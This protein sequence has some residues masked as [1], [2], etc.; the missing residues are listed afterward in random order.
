MSSKKNLYY[1]TYFLI[2]IGLLVSGYLLFNHFAIVAGKPFETD[3]C[4]IVFGKG[5]NAAS[6]SN[7]SIF[8]NIPVGGW[9]LIYL[10]VLLCLTILSQIFLSKLNEIIQ[11]AFWI[12]F[13]ALF[14]SLF[15][16]GITALN[17]VLLC[18]FCMVF[19]ILNFALFLLIKKLS[20]KSFKELFRGLLKAL[21]IV[22]LGKPV[23]DHFSKWKWLTLIIPLILALAIYQWVIMEGQNIRIQKLE[24]YDPLVELEKFEAIEVWDIQVSS[25]DPMLGPKDAPVSLVVFSD[26]QCDICEMFATNFEH[27]INYNKGKLNIIFKYFPLSSQ[28]NPI[29]TDDLH[30]S[31]CK[32]ALAAEAAHQQG[33][34][35][36]YHDAMFEKGIQGDEKL[37]VA[38][39]QSLNL[40]MEKFKSDYSSLKSQEKITVDILEGNRLNIDGTP[41]VFLNGRKVRELSQKNINFLVKYLSH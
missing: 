9:G 5:C 15:Y 31:A 8:M 32:A 37:F 1:A 16:I 17:P 21:G 4:S 6:F 10:S 40:N 24:S 34:F 25:E 3:L 12:S 2:T 38:I 28:C 36:E 23:S 41:T 29:I 27:L 39:A 18:P 35:W 30:P 22:F 13:V 20:Q 7:V 26:F 33:R 11:I 14:I 19:H